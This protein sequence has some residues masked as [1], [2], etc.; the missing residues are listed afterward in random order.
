[1]RYPAIIM[2][3]L[4]TVCWGFAQDDLIANPGFEQVDPDDETMP[5]GWDAHGGDTEQLARR[6]TDDA[7]TGDRALLIIDDHSSEE[8]VGYAEATSGIVQRVDGIEPGV[9]Y[10]LSAWAKCL[11]RERDNAAWLQLR[12]MPSGEQANTH[13]NSEIGEWRQFSALAHAPEDTTHA[14]VYIKTLHTASSRY[15]VDD[16][17]LETAAAG[18]DD[19]RL[20][21][22]PF[23][24][25]GIAPEQVHE[26]NLHTPLVVDGERAAH[27]VVPNDRQWHDVGIR[28]REAIEAKTGAQLE[29]IA[30][31]GREWAPLQSEQTTIAIGHLDNNFVVER[32]WL[33]R[34]QEVNMNH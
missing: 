25:E 30:S 10:K 33:Q 28:L 12:F 23:G 17:A 19:Q 20:A 14:M 24:S 29:V 21:L 16:F 2:A 27:I 3:L 11:S 32:M 31:E 34:Y 8:R 26:P 5:A 9:H 22:F 7:H 13:L 1:M 15:V 6:L 4:L 18:P